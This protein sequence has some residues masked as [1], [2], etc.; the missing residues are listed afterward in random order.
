MDNQRDNTGLAESVYDQ[1][2]KKYE[3]GLASSTDLTNA[4]T[5]L[6]LA[7]SNYIN[8]LYNAVVAKV[9]YLKAIGKI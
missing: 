5:D 4:Q 2:K 3:S 9:D 7:Q 1:T 8:A 6:I